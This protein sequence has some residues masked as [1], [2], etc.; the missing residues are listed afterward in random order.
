MGNQIAAILDCGWILPI[1][2]P[3]LL[4]GIHKVAYF[5]L[6]SS[7]V[8]I[9]LSTSW[10]YLTGRSALAIFL[11]SYYLNLPDLCAVV[12]VSHEWLD[13][14]IASR[15]LYQLLYRKLRPAASSRTP[16]ALS[17]QYVGY[18]FVHV[19]LYAKSLPLSR[20][21]STSNSWA[22]ISMSLTVYSF[23]VLI[24]NVIDSRNCVVCSTHLLY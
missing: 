20:L 21:M 4:I 19:V 5:L 12:R 24:S 22:L 17:Q 8:N 14:A 11:K 13:T 16:L 2:W 6:T 9:F 15:A 7:F 18:L 23:T 10:T 1:I 3:C